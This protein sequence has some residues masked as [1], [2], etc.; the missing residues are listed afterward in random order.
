MGKIH[1]MFDNSLRRFA[2][3][4]CLTASMALAVVTTPVFAADTTNGSTVSVDEENSSDGCVN[5]HMISASLI[6]DICWECVFPIIVSFGIISGSDRKDMIPE[7]AAEKPYC[8]CQDN[9]G[10]P[11][12]GIQTSLWEPF[13]AVEF[14]RTSGCS[15]VLNGVRFPFDKLF[16]G[17]AEVDPAET[18]HSGW[19]TAFRHYHYYSFP[20]LY[21]L[22]MFIPMNC[23]PGGYVDLDAMYLSE[24]DPT[25]NH[26]EL[27]FF[28]NPEMV[29]FATALTTISCIPDG[30]T[31]L[32]GKPMESLFWCAGSWGPIVPLV[33]TI[34]APRETL[35]ATSALMA[36]VLYILHRRAVEWRSM[37]EDA[38]CGGE[39]STYLPKTM[40]RFSLFWPVP[41]TDSNHPFGQSDLIWGLGR[42]RPATGED[43][44]YII[45]RWL[46]CCNTL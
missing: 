13:R 9:N 10:I 16:Q 20:A 23:N 46:D 12:P 18:A 44:V 38:M 29:L 27:A 8:M 32:F 35:A 31:S 43:P 15:Q 19:Q 33:G 24:V 36:K 26:D 2:A 4:A 5:A 11:K 7:G 1:G 30:F 34:P 39:I 14:V 37:G 25:W 42:T 41:E 40:Y 21:M 28:T 45:W 17:N 22:D 3:G 6:T